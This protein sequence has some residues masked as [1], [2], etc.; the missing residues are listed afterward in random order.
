MAKA[1]RFGDLVRGSGRPQVVTLWVEPKK[2]KNF[3]KAIDENRVP[4]VLTDPGSHRKEYGRIGFQQQEGAIYL[5]FPK[6]LPPA[7][8]VERVV[9]INYQLTED[10]PVT[11]PVT[12]EFRQEMARKAQAEPHQRIHADSKKEKHVAEAAGHPAHHQTPSPPPP[13]LAKPKLKK[14]EIS[15]RRIATIEEKRR[16]KAETQEEAKAVALK[17]SKAKPFVVNRAE[18]SVEISEVREV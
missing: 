16:I 11:D 13:V 3:S 1:I 18:V 9:G 8:S 6:E 15:V 7:N 10:R 5:V 17:E 2:D 12:A 4:T 14:F